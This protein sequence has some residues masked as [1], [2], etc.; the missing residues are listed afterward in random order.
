MIEAP[1]HGGDVAVASRRYG[2]APALWLDL[3]A[4]LNPE[5]Y[6]LPALPAACFQQ[7]PELEGLLAAARDYYLEGGGL[8]SGA[9]DCLV[10]AAGSQTLIQALPLLRAPCRVAVPAVGYREH[11]FRWQLAGHTVIEYDP[12]QLAQIDALAATDAD[13]LVVINPNNP[14]G[15]EVGLPR[16]Q[17][18]LAQLQRRGGW[19]V[20]DEAF[21]DATPALSL[22]PLLPEP[23][24]IL[25]RS[26]GKFFG[27]A[28]MRCGFALCEPALAEQLRL[29]L[30]PWPVSGPTVLVAM[31]ALDDRDWQ[32][33]ARPRLRAASV[34]C[35]DLLASA[36]RRQ[37]GEVLRSALFNSVRL[38]LP[39]AQRAQDRMAQQA[40]WVRLIELAEGDALLRFGLVSPSQTEPWRR[41]Q[42]GLVAVTGE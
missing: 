25:L 31:H 2:I 4:A 21:V 39:A 7:L 37:G 3:S 11:A 12:L 22:A 5:P 41:F 28:G 32:R 24:L 19:L 34:A 17:G 13:V 26:L 30:G 6:S 29:A 18:W 16:L 27:L 40:V 42:A 33:R 9:V 10:A 14:L 1:R 15:C 23:G 35:G 8:E 36:F 20:V 38:P